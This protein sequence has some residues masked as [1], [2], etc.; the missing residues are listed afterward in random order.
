MRRRLISLILIV[1]AAAA[2]LTAALVT[3]SSPYLGL[4][5]QGGISVVLAPTEEED[6][7]DLGGRVDQAVE[8]IRQRVDGLGV[9]EPEIT[10]QGDAVVVDLPGVDD[11]ERVLELLGSTAELRFRPVLATQPA[12]EFFAEEEPPE[13]EEE[14]EEPEDPKELTAP[15]DDDPEAEVY[16]EFEREEPDEETGE[17]VTTDYVYTL[18]PMLASGQIVQDAQASLDE[19]GAWYVGLKFRS[20][21]EGLDQFNQAAGVCF[22]A[23]QGAPDPQCPTG[24]LAIVLDSEIQ[25][26]PGIQQ[27][28]FERE[29]AT[30]TGEFSS[31]EAKDLALALRY[32]ALPV[33]LERQSVDTVSASV[34]DDS[35]RAGIVAGI[36]GLVL[37]ALY[38][39]FYYRA[40]GAVVIV[41]MGLWAALMYSVVAWFGETQGLALTLAGVTGVIISVGITVDSYVVYFERL[42][43]DVKLGRTL[44]TAAD[45]AFKRAFKTILAAN[46]S[47]LIGAAVLWYMTV[48]AVRGFAFFLGLSSLLGLLVTATFTGPAVSLLSR[49]RFFSEARGL[50][51]VGAVA[52]PTASRPPAGK[53]EVGATR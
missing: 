27:P 51:L 3:R 37:V 35:L 23:S 14:A 11:R 34:G 5:L 24:Q 43:D 8:I 36:I 26:A 42:K 28:T 50:G 22:P 53:T 2:G 7:E 13:G 52:T 18:G 17:T 47:T 40:L 20:G 16:F 46:T 15:E 49:S 21:E 4:D 45:S 31:R 33:E 12:E 39:M 38:M 41:G 19:A 25:S 44:R 9:A 10:R 6:G 29:G 32:G 48:G 30:I 1:A